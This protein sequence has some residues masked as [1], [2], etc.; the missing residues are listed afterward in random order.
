MCFEAF[1]VRGQRTLD[2]ESIVELLHAIYSTYYKQ[3][4]TDAEVRTAAEVMFLN[5]ASPKKQHHKQQLY[6]ANG[7]GGEGELTGWKLIDES[8]HT[9]VRGER[10]H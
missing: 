7:N 1:D 9:F 10:E 4:P 8:T 5:V 3:P 6:A 2:G